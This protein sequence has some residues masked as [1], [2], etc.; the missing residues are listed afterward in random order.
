MHTEHQGTATQHTQTDAL[1]AEFTCPA[2][3]DALVAGH[4]RAAY[5]GR[6][7][8]R[9]CCCNDV[10]ALAALDRV[11]CNTPRDPWKTHGTAPPPA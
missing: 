4:C 1:V 11:A 8:V 3:R 2:C 6:A 10:V 9:A 5:P 7:Q